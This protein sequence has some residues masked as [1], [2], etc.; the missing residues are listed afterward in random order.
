MSYPKTYKKAINYDDHKYKEDRLK[1]DDE[2]NVR[3]VDNVA[4]F[5]AELQAYKEDLKASYKAEKHSKLK[6]T[7][8]EINKIFHSSKIMRSFRIS[9]NHIELNSLHKP[10]DTEIQKRQN[11]INYYSDV[12]NQFSDLLNKNNKFGQEVQIVQADIHFDQTSPHL[13]VHVSNLYERE[14]KKLNRKNVNTCN[15]DISDAIKILKQKQRDI[16][17]EEGIKLAPNEIFARSLRNVNSNYALTNKIDLKKLFPE[18]Y[19]LFSLK[20]N[21][22][23]NEKSW[24]LDKELFFTNA[25]SNLIKLGLKV[26]QT[27]DIKK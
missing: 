22:E 9:C 13:H 2:I 1:K 10:N 15:I 21:A 5:E 25:K 12:L 16:Y 6:K 11:I 14:V 24:R 20:K 8:K 26:D 19:D 23:L 18:Q 27:N 3:L 4:L 17:K 7:N